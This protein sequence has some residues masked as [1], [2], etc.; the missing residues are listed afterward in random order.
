LD[1]A[2]YGH[3]QPCHTDERADDE[4]AEG[5]RELEPF[6]P[7]SFESFAVVLLCL[8]SLLLLC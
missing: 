3:V 7:P 2:V 4:R 1:D 5:E 8:F 6:V